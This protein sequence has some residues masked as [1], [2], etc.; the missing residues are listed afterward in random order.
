MLKELAELRSQGVLSDAEFEVE[1][2]RL[3]HG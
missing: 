1:K 3:L 2:A